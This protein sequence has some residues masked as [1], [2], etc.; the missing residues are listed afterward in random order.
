GAEHPERLTIIGRLGAGHGVSSAEATLTEWARQI[1]SQQ[2]EE[3]RA[4]GVLLRSKATALAL[5]PELLW[6]FSPLAAAFGLALLLA[7]ANVASMMLARAV[8]RQREIGIRLSL[9]AARG[10]LI[11]QLLTES[12]LLSVPAALLGW[13]VSR[14][15]IEVSLRGM[16][17]T[18]PRDMLE[19][20]HE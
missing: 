19:L 11:R 3:R 14:V 5:T 7:C 17:A 15:T 8:S 4:A 2:P 6:L 1:T 12:I 20:L 13:I 16:Y 18:V 9:G 10:R